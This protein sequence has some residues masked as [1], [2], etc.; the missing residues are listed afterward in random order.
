MKGEPK[1]GSYLKRN[2]QKSQKTLG[3]SFALPT[4][5][6]LDLDLDYGF[7]FGLWIMGSNLVL[8]ISYTSVTVGLGPSVLQTGEAGAGVV[9][10]PEPPS[11]L[12]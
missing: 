11:N 12:T 5:E 1:N 9:L 7:G 4:S 3:S 6:Q 10:Q 8:L 2:N